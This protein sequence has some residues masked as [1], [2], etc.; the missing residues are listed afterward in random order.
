M[1]YKNCMNFLAEISFDEYDTP[2]RQIQDQ[3][4]IWDFIYPTKIYVTRRPYMQPDVFVQ[5]VCECH[6]EQE[7]GLQLVF[8]LGKKTNQN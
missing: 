1:A 6:W 4:Q 8:K 2:L 7:H 5:V 3:H